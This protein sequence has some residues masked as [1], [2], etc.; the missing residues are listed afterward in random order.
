M[1]PLDTQRNLD[2]L[3]EEHRLS[4]M[5]HSPLSNEMI[6]DIK[7]ITDKDI[8]VFREFFPCGQERFRWYI[9]DVV[10]AC[11]F[12][13]KYKNWINAFEKVE[14]NLYVWPQNDMKW[15][16]KHMDDWIIKERMK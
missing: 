14:E 12:F 15:W 6:K 3:G 10:D 11:P 9:L 4:V 13:S 5:Y 7:N 2:K 1:L 16:S 8:F